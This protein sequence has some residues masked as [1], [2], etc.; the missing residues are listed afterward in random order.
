MRRFAAVVSV[1]C[2]SRPI[3]KVALH[4]AGM[5]QVVCNSHQEAMELVLEGHCAAL[6]VDF[7]LPGA[8]DIL[9]TAALL[10]A[11]LRPLLLALSGAW[12]GTG[13]AFQSGASRILYKPLQLEQV[14]DAFEPGRGPRKKLHRSPRYELRSLVYLELESG[15]MP[16]IGINISEQGM[17][18]RTAEQIT[19]RSNVTFRCV[20]PGSKHSLHGHADVIWADAQGRA[21]MFFS[22]LSPSARRHLKHWLR[23]L[24]RNNTNAARSLL[25]SADK[26]VFAAPHA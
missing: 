1:D 6:I 7:D 10:P 3:L 15:S 11:P 8:A 23:K 24:G 21:G 9:K 19:P 26:A 20:L 13:Q 17:A 16:A 5:E 18:I 14:R 25:P 22:R 12:A 4:E 2:S